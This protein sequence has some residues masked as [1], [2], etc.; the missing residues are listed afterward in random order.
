ME[1]TPRLH[2]QFHEQSKICDGYSCW[3]IL[4][5]VRRLF[6]IAAGF[7]LILATLTPLMEL[8]DHW[9][10]NVAPINDTE[11]NVTAWFV[12][13]GLVLTLSTLVPY[14]PALAGSRRQTRLRLGAPRALRP[15]DEDKCPAAT[16]SPPLIPL[17]I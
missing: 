10:G 13:V 4:K 11:L 16:G 17:R 14:I 9:D 5:A 15:T 8:V 3:A 2:R 6:Q 12:G 1:I 7:V